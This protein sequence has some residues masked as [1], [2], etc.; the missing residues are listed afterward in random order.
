MKKPLFL[1][2]SVT[3]F[4]DQGNIDEKGNVAVY[5]YLISNGMDGVVVMGSTGEFFARPIEQKKRLINIAVDCIKGRAQCFIG[6]GG[7]SVQETVMLSNYACKAGADAVMIVAPYYFA[8]SPENLEAYYDAVVSQIDGQVFLYNYPNC[9]GSDITAD[10]T[11]NL[12]RKHENIVGIKDTVDNFGHTRSII[13]A[14]KHE[15][16]DFKIL[17]GYDENF[18]H[19]MLSG[20]CGCIGGLSNIVPEVFAMWRQAIEKNDGTLIETCQHK[21]NTLMCLYAQKAPFPYIAK[22]GLTLRG[23][24]INETSMHFSAAP[25]DTEKLSRLIQNTLA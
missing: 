24:P 20:G 12:R 15:Y 4:D 25:I 9:T 1:T 13:E 22:R 2:P 6:T 3:I 21:V 8:L 18:Y 5:D 14:V 19:I 10:I 23:I 17:S 16:P 7:L 11:V